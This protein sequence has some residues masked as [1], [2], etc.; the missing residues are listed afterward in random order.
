MAI[1]EEK[2]AYAETIRQLI[3]V[4]ELPAEVQ[5]EIIKNADLIELNKKDQIFN[6]GDR[7]GY[8]FYLIEGEIDLVANAQVS[9]SIK[10]STD[11]SKY[12]MAQLQPRQFTGVAK[13]NSI[14]MRIDRNSLDKLL[15]VH[16]GQGESADAFGDGLG[17]NTSTL[18]V[19]IIDG[20]EK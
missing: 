8:S 16:Q 10:A 4:N 9:S 12:P 5:N 3:P 19:D 15:V 17:D 20:D 18:E 2:Q 1:P 14:V 13:V 6:Q 11:R 7:D